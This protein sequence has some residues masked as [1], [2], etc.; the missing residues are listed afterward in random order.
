L[1]NP[2]ESGR[3]LLAVRP[4]GKYSGDH[5][6][7]LILTSPFSVAASA[8]PSLAERKAVATLLKAAETRV[9]PYGYWRRTHRFAKRRSKPLADR[10]EDPRAVRS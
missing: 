9:R 10:E 6:S 4:V 7:V 2:P 8:D 3:L 1:A 5:P